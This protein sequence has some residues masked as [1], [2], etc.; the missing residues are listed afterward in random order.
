LKRFTD[1]SDPPPRTS[2]IIKR[3]EGKSRKE[4][5]KEKEKQIKERKTLKKE[6]KGDKNKK[7]E[8]LHGRKNE[9]V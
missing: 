3:K 9:K 6:E 2:V 7:N 4:K 1:T 5:Q 8:Y